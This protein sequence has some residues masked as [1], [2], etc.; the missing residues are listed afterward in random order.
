MLGIFSLPI[1]TFSK[2]ALLTVGNSILSTLGLITFLSF[3]H[4]VGSRLINK[5][6]YVFLY[7]LVIA[8]MNFCP[9]ICCGLAAGRIVGGIKVI[10]LSE[11][12]SL[13]RTVFIC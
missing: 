5:F 2:V 1:C 9:F 8:C 6:R 4:A 10:S 13:T 12:S 7:I 3:L 11:I